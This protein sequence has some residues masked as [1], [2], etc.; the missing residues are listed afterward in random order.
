[1]LVLNWV[2]S[3]Q[4][5]H[6]ILIILAWIKQD[7]R[8]AVW[9][10]L[11]SRFT[12]SRVEWISNCSCWLQ[13]MSVGSSGFL[14]LIKDFLWFCFV[15]MYLCMFLCMYMH[16]RGCLQRKSNTL[17]QMWAAAVSPRDRVG[18][19]CKSSECVQLLSLPAAQ[20]KNFLSKILFSIN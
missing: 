2:S 16:V 12:F 19:S 18:F 10:V 20:S 6:F 7:F 11:S 9:C 3:G 1:M 5:A 17:E 15:L 14:P 4:N 8:P 13:Q